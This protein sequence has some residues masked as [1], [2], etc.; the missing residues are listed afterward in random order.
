M[1]TAVGLMLLLVISA[2]SAAAPAPS[3]PVAGAGEQHTI[4]THCGFYETEFDGI[5][6]TPD[7]IGRGTSPEGTGF[8]ATIGTMTR[9]GD[10]ALFET[11]TGLTIWFKPAPDDLPPIPPCD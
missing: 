10:R 9:Q 8:N 5:R 4:F 2:C 11:D 7:S 3:A 6:W 1:Q